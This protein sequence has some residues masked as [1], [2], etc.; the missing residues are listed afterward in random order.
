M[1]DATTKYISNI[2][3]YK[4]LKV[5]FSFISLS[6]PYSCVIC[7]QSRNNFSCH[8]PH[9]STYISLANIINMSTAQGGFVWQMYIIWEKRLDVPLS[10]KTAEWSTR[11]YRETWT[12]IDNK[13]TRL[14]D[15]IQWP[16][17]LLCF[18]FWTWTKFR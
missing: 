10:T 11:K 17:I 5:Y 6:N 7:Q 1:R 14:T 8:A 16:H 12:L 2:S 9:T 13:K 18:S 15:D 3:Y 4:F